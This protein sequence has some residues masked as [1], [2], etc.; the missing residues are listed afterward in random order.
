MRFFRYWMCWLRH[1]PEWKATP[2]YNH[3]GEFSH[4]T[5]RCKKCGRTISQD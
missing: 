2:I 5:L 1:V 3:E 4:Y